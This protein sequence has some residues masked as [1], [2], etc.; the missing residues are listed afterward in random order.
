[1]IVRI[2]QFKGTDPKAPNQIAGKHPTGGRAGVNGRGREL[3]GGQEGSLVG[4]DGLLVI[5]GGGDRGGGGMVVG[6]LGLRDEWRRGQ[7]RLL[8]RIVVRRWIRG[9]WIG[10]GGLLV[11]VMIV[12]GL[13]H[14]Q[15]WTVSRGHLHGLRWI[16]IGGI[17][18]GVG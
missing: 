14:G 11:H 10:L 12:H 4:L 13:V 9:V 6:L 17:V 3:L 16:R 2:R 15:R 8:V 1:M 5:A 18:R 7:R